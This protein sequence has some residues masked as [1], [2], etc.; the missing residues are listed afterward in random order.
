L[1]HLCNVKTV[2]F[3]FRFL[4]IAGLLVRRAVR[5]GETLMAFKASRVA[6]ATFLVT[7]LPVLTR[8]A[9]T[10]TADVSAAVVLLSTELSSD[11][12]VLNLKKHYVERQIA[13]KYTTQQSGECAVT[14][15]RDARTLYPHFDRNPL[16]VELPTYY[17][18]PLDTM[19]KSLAVSNVQYARHDFEMLVGNPGGLSHR[20]YSE[21]TLVPLIG[22]KTDVAPTEWTPAEFDPPLYPTYYTLTAAKAAISALAKAG[23]ACSASSPRAVPI[24]SPA[25]TST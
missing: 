5:T 11:D 15:H 3:Y 9:V 10:S 18:I 6:V 24:E 23:A 13:V 4:T 7:T 22:L 16:P 21:D 20:E 12:I 17:Q 14:I 2:M 1:Q 8:S 19:S 25:S